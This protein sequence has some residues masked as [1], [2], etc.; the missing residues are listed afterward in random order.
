M[1]SAMLLLAVHVSGQPVSRAPDLTLQL[2]RAER[3]WRSGASLLEAK[4]RVDRVL[5]AAPDDTAALMLRAHVLLGME[6]PADALRDAGRAAAL[7]PSNGEALLLVCEA[8]RLVGQR[9]RAVD[10]LERAA[11]LAFRDASLHVRLAWNAAE[12]GLLDR[13]EA[14][15]RIALQQDPGL[16]VAYVQ[17]ARIFVQQRQDEAAVSVLV[18][19]LSARVLGASAVRGDP[20]LAPLA[21][22]PA[23][24]PYLR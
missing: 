16:A 8:A 17:L 4:A 7:A 18:R 11:S 20:M 2:H 21:R 14:F 23:L 5:D 6:R 22:Y 19:G 1:M 12:L 10:A 24:R 9:A 15:A 3:A 13:A